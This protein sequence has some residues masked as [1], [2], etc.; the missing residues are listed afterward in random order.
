MSRKLGLQR[1]LFVIGITQIIWIC[2]ALGVFA[3]FVGLG[4]MFLYEDK[5]NGIDRNA[6]EYLLAFVPAL[7]WLGINLVG[8]ALLWVVGW[9]VEGFADC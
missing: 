3:W 5:V 4:V 7:K 9:V 1:L 8:I 6:L 2:V